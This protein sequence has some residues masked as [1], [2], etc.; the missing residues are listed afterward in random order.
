MTDQ[1]TFSSKPPTDKTEEYAMQ[2]LGDNKAADE[3]R[4]MHAL[5]ASCHVNVAKN[6]AKEAML[7]PEPNDRVDKWVQIMA[8]TEV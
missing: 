2:Q 8:S 1:L 3:H 4:Q 7:M 6:Q 5:L